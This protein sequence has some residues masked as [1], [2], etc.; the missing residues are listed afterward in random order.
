MLGAIFHLYPNFDRI[1]CN[2]DQMPHFVASDF[3]LHY[4]PKSH[5]KDARLIWVKQPFVIKIF[6][7]SYF[8]WPFNIGFTVLL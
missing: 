6:V 3:G 7:L 1:F 8:E 4:L 5:K 2:P